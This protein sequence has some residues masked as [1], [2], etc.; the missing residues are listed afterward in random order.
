MT[1]LLLFFTIGEKAK[2][3]MGLQK[4]KLELLQ[5]EVS[6]QLGHA[7]RASGDG[8]EGRQSQRPRIS[9]PTVLGRTKRRTGSSARIKSAGEWRKGMGKST[10]LPLTYDSDQV[11]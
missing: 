4:L 10:R 1:S 11:Q 5:E 2:V 6:S 7:K 3:T 8:D 9:G